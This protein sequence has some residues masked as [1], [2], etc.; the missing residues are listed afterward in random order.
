MDGS[1]VSVVGGGRK[2]F[3]EQQPAEALTLM[4]EKEEYTTHLKKSFL[5]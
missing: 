1:D 2:K 3:Q 5:Q 4:G